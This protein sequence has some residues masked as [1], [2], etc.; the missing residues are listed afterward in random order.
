MKTLIVFEDTYGIADIYKAIKGIVVDSID[1][2]SV[3]DSTDIITGYKN[4]NSISLCGKIKNEIN[5]YDL[6]VSVFDVD[7]LGGKN[8]NV[9]ASKTEFSKLASRNKGVFTH[10]YMPIVYNSETVMLYQYL[11]SCGSMDV[12]DIV[13]QNDTFEFQSKVLS[14]IINL[15]RQDKSVLSVKKVRN[16]LDINKLK[17]G[18]R[19]GSNI[20][21]FFKNWILNDCCIDESLFAAKEVVE[22]VL[23][24]VQDNLDYQLSRNLSSVSVSNKYL[25][26]LN[27]SYNEYALVNI[28]NSEG[29][30]EC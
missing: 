2:V 18:L 29:G 22:K 12:V 10:L 13:N 30:Y 16:Y 17:I 3:D 25:I 21:R 28:S 23:D 19:V 7:K 15:N 6:I 20:N 9:I 26:N 5:K 1:I 27:A 11:I 14:E 4:I 24:E 8:K